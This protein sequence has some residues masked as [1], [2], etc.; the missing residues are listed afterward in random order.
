V[1]MA[2]RMP[3]V[4]R[5]GQ[6]ATACGIG[7]K[8]RKPTSLVV[9][10]SEDQVVEQHDLIDGCLFLDS[11]K[12]FVLQ[13]VMPTKNNFALIALAESICFYQRVN[14]TV[15][16]NFSRGQRWCPMLG[17]ESAS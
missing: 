1:L 13:F 15:A 6:A 17:R 3:S 7:G 2:A 11:C 4:D 14:H 10:G 5:S 16:N 9:T 8:R 12:R